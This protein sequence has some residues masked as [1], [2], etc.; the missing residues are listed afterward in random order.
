M[1]KEFHLT[2]TQVGL[3][4]SA[5]IWLYAIIGVPLGRIA[6]VWS[7][8]RLLALG[9]V[10]WSALTAFTYFVG[11]F[12]MLLVSRLGVGVGEAACAP[13]ATSWLGDLVP[14]PNRA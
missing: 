9:V 12:S 5:F 7:R 11:S 2:D 8:K 14:P 1:R 3:L 4:G 10:I 13:T 6:D